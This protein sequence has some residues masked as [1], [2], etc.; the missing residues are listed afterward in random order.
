MSEHFTTRLTKAMSTSNSDQTTFHGD[1]TLVAS[2]C[3][4]SLASLSEIATSVESIKI[5]QKD[6]MEIGCYLYRASATIVELQTTENTS[7]NAAVIRQSLSKSMLLAIDILEGFQ[8]NELSSTVKQLEAVINHMGECLSS[9][10]PSTFEKMK[11]AEI[12]AR[13][14][15]R[16]MKMA[17]FQVSQIQEPKPNKQLPEPLPLEEQ[18]EIASTIAESDL[19]S[20]IADVSQV[21]SQLS[22]IPQPVEVLRSKSCKNPSTKSLRNLREAAQYVEPLYESFFC[23]LTKEI[24]DDPVTI[25]SGVTYERKAITE[26]FEEF[27][28]SEEVICPATENKLVSRALSP[29]IALKAAIDE[30]KD[31]NDIARIKVIHKALSLYNTESMVLDVLDDLRDICQR[32]R[33][34]IVE[35]HNIG[36]TQLLAKLLEYKDRKVRCNALEILRHLAEDD[37][38]GKELIGKTTAITMSVRMLSSSYQPIRHAALLLLVELSKYESLLDKIGRVAGG[39]LLLIRTKYGRSTDGFASDAA[40]QILG[41]LAQCPDNIKCMA[42]NG[43]FEPLLDSLIKGSEEMKTKIATY[44]G[45]IVLGHESKTYVAERAAPALIHMV[46]SGNPFARKAA[47]KALSQISANHLN[48]RILVEAGIMKIM[49][50]E[51]FTRKIYDEPID[52]LK[53][54]SGILANILESGSELE[55]IK[56]NTQG[57]TMASNYVVLN[58]I[59]MIESSN[60]DELNLNL[61]RILS[62]LTKSPKSA[63]TIVSAV[64]ESEASYMLVDMINS[65]NEELGIAVIKLLTTLSPYMGHTLVDRLSKMN[66]QPESLIQNTSNMTQITERKALS[67]KFLA[68]LPHQNLTLNLALLSTNTVPGILQ[69]INH[70]QRNGI[71][72]SRYASAYL[73]GLVGILVRFTATLYEPRVLSELINYNFT[74]VFTDLL[75]KT[76]SNEIKRLAA[77]GLQKL[78]TQTINLSKPP[79]PNRKKFMNLI[80]LLNFRCFGSSSKSKV[81]VCPVHRGACSSQSTFCLI[82]ARAVEGLLACLDHQDPEVVEDA[83]SALCTLLDDKVDL[84]NSVKMLNEMNA[85]QQVMKVVKD[86]KKESVW[87]KAFWMIERFLTKGGHRIAFAVSEDRLFDTT[88]VTAFHHGDVYTRQMTEKILMYLDKMPSFTNTFTM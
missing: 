80:Y 72:S 17:K 57:H 75:M 36:I 1:I 12:T 41:N 37:D 44:L 53:E 28:N 46:H 25:Q 23:P 15:S 20:I 70:I 45:E 43:F 22:D 21:N 35:V 42:E 88:L 76:H 31:R 4:S 48:G 87:Q 55:T 14:L 47:F 19:Y 68:A 40:D 86:H 84:D 73:E 77:N 52:S 32:R 74:T 51:M 16:E 50:E 34:K 65:P 10:P 83:L 79:K 5:E 33:D 13:S 78:S 38:E 3:E 61:I 69:T 2:L 62:C 9:I 66:G 60:P 30:W 24:M 29:N 56:V 82:E 63:D 85:T 59:Y 39:I 64:K 67:A 71:R 49:I 27:E 81:H 11:Y 18:P 7:I 58:I 6:F 54:A 26:W 8:P